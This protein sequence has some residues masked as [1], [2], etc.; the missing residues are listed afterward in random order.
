MTTTIRPDAFPDVAQ[1]PISESAPPPAR[2]TGGWIPGV[3][4]PFAEEFNY[5]L[6]RTPKWLRYID[7]RMP[8][9]WWGAAV[10]EH[11]RIPRDPLRERI[12][13]ALLQPLDLN[14][15]RTHRSGHV[16]G[17]RDEFLGARLGDE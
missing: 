7:E 10:L 4:R 2:V 1:T 17:A 14:F 5:L 12:P 16:E 3:D 11:G 6:G 13:L 15:T 9:S 8:W